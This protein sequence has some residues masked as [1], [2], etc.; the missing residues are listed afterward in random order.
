VVRGFYLELGPMEGRIIKLSPVD[1]CRKGIPSKHEK[2]KITVV[3]ARDGKAQIYR[4]LSHKSKY[5][6]DS[7]L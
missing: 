5:P 7:M 4:I 2:F 3:L 6:Q 1:I